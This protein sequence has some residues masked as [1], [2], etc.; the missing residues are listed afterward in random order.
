MLT[1]KEE[2]VQEANQIRKKKKVILQPREGEET[3]S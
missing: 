3:D 1:S 2:R